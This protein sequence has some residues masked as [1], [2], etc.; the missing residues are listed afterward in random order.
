MKYF[1]GKIFIFS[2]VI[3]FNNYCFGQNIFP[4]KQSDKWLYVDKS[5]NPI[6]SKTYSFIYP[7]IG[8]RAIACQ[9]KKY[10]VID[11][12]EEVIIPFKYDTISYDYPYLYCIK[13]KK[14][15][16][17]DLN[18][19]LVPIIIGA[20]G[21]VT[22]SERSCFTIIKNKKIQ[23]LDYTKNAYKPDTLPTQ[24]DE[25]IE[26]SSGVAVVKISNKW[27]TIYCNGQFINEFHF[28]S[29]KVFEYSNRDKYR[30][31]KYYVD[32]QM[33]FFNSSGKVITKPKFKELYFNYNEFSLV[34]TLDNRIVYIDNNG[35]E[36]YK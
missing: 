5:F 13:S 21:G 11:E 36:Y 18:G 15:S 17:F 22:S 1:E 26:F 25:F 31:S 8:T 6:S 28:D 35:R 30:L 24:Y 12:K 4:F 2:I 23:I 32:G 10:G 20:C 34:K 9:G 19:K 16:Q 14:A 33:G 7:F 3:I 29:V 27:Q